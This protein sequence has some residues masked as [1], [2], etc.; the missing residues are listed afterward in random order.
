MVVD[1]PHRVKVLKFLHDAM[2]DA[3]DF[4]KMNLKTG[5]HQIRVNP[6]DIETTKFNINYG[7]F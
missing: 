1:I 3:H 2:G 5:F 4:S 7:K 6:D